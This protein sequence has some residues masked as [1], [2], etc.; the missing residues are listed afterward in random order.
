MNVFV[1]DIF[2]VIVINTIEIGSKDL[3]RAVKKGEL[4]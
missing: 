4:A 3:R 2:G 1:I